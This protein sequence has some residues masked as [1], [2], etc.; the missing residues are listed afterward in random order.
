MMAV[1]YFAAFE[2]TRAFLPGMLARGSGHVINLTSPASRLVWPGA[3][4]Y[5]AA[6]WAM[7]GFSEALRADLAGTGIDVTLVVPGKVASRYFEANPG[8]EERIPRISSLIPTLSPEAVAA[9]IVGVIERPR[10]E[11]VLPAMLRLLFLVHHVAPW[12]VE[13]LMVRTGWRR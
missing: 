12:P 3:N 1:P 10:R 11:V 4:A 8:S 6:R 13:A 2:M 5:T 9:A 7:R